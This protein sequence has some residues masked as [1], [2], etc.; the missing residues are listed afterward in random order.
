MKILFFPS[1][2]GGGFGH[3]NRC[4]AIAQEA[5]QRGHDCAFVTNTKKYCLS[6]SNDFQTY[7][8][9]TNRMWNSIL[10][11]IKTILFQSD[12]RYSPIFTEF[13]G[14]D[15]QVIRDGLVD[16][17]VVKEILTQYVQ[18]V[19]HYNPHLLIGDTN[20]LAWI[21]S[22]KVNV[23][24]VQIV[25]YA[26]HP[27]TAKLIWWK[28]APEGIVQPNSSALFNPLLREMGLKPIKRAEDLLRGDLFIV[29]SIPEI[30][31]IPMT[32]KTIH[33]GE[34]TI[35]SKNRE[36]PSWFEEIDN[37]QPL[38][39]ITIGGGAEG[40]GNKLFFSIIVEAFAKKP[41]QVVVSTTNKFYSLNFK[42]LPKNIRFFQWVPGKLIISKADLVIFHGGYGT[43]MESIASG[44]PTI[45]LPFHSEQE[46]NGRR[47][48]QLGCG[49]VVK[50]SR[51]PYKRI[52]GKWK[53]GNYSFLVQN[54]YDLTAEELI[55]E[56]NKILFNNEYLKKAQ[57]LQTRIRKFHGVKKTMEL[58]EKYWS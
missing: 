44:K 13:H 8:I 43:M 33:V 45:T 35:S 56:V 50:L 1:D 53:Y 38:F 54:R 40:V 7:T 31:P 37:S 20:L 52:E 47:L 41:I 51:E 16:E 29:P 6:L 4:L 10:S 42:G 34:L 17:Q 57:N 26:S 11:K 21:L 39:Y 32:R 36:I 12:S 28:N 19:K 18:I 58:I 25:R 49:I 15:F 24:I 5:Q 30:E 55:N 27:T 23:P 9:R 46:G 22:K 14:L 2:L 48:E 3:I